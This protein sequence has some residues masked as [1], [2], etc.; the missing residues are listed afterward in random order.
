[1]WT[2][3]R[4]AAQDPAQEAELIRRNPFALV[5]STVD[6]VPVATHAPVLPGEEGTLVGHMA[7][8]NP[9]WRSFESSPDVLVVFSGPH[10]YVSPTVYGTDPAVPTWDYAAVHVTGRVELIDDALEVVERTVAAAESLRSPSW[11]PTPASRERFRALLPGVVA[12]RVRVRTQQSVFKL[13]QD[14]DAER[15]ARVRA[16]AA[17]D[18]PRLA[19]LMGR[20]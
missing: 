20:S 3:P 2:A 19:E 13:S 5:V 1:M 15:Y 18:N 14:I 16:S 12:F 6:G 7:R 11:E 17:A 10:G 4:Y 9:Q 8:A